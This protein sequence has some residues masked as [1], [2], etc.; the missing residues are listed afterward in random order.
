[1]TKSGPVNESAAVVASGIRPTA[2]YQS[3]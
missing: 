3:A 1:V 2:E